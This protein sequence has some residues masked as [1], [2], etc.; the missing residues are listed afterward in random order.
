MDGST[1]PDLAT[2]FAALDATW[3]AAA[4]LRTGPW[5]LREG[6]GGGKR[7]S[8]ATAETPASGADIMTA[9]TAM[10]A[11][12]QVPLFMIRPG[13]D[14]LDAALEARGYRVID[15]VALY[16]A[17][18][19]EIEPAPRM[20][21]FDIWPPL[22]IAETIWTEAGIGPERQAVMHRVRGAKTCILGRT[23]DRAAGAAFVAL[24]GS[25]AMLHALE[26]VPGLRRKGSAA[27]MMRCAASW[28]QDHGAD[29][30]TLAVTEAN[31]AARALYASLKME[32]VGNYHYRIR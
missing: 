31:D 17:R 4:T 5:R 30:L 28:A 21:A 22:A 19:A 14:T 11:M 26:V 7:V 16:M 29:W 9:E 8:A 25:V 6:R 15:P 13:D 3:P 24:D 20:T 1:R 10:E 2:L 23:T 27:H 12:G 18:S 32:V